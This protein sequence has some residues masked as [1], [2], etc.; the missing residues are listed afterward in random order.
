MKMSQNISRIFDFS[1]V[2]AFIKYIVYLGFLV[3]IPKYW[4][5]ITWK[6]HLRN[7]GP[8]PPIDKIKQPQEY[9]YEFTYNLKM[10]V[11]F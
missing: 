1:R 8:E 4:S 7:K 2:S 11:G 10:V 9:L 3:P 6:S 5:I